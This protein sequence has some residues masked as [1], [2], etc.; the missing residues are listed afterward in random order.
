M[1][2]APSTKVGI[3]QVRKWPT[4]AD[5]GPP[6]EDPRMLTHDQLMAFCRKF[7][8]ER[9]LSVYLNADQRDPAQRTRWKTMLSQQL[10]AIRRGLP[11][12]ERNAFEEAVERVRAELDGFE[13]FLPKRGF[14]AFATSGGL[15][16]A[17]T[18]PVAMP[19]LARWEPGIRAAPYIRALGRR[20]P[21]VL[22]LVD[23]RRARLFC[24]Q[25]G[26]LKESG[27]FQADTF[28]GDLSDAHTGKRPTTRSGVRGQTSS[29]AAQRYL[30]VS[31]DHMVKAAMD[32]AV[33]RAG[34][35]GFL[36]VGGTPE[37]VSAAAALAPK[38]MDGRIRESPSLYVDIK[39]PELRPALEEIAMDMTNRY[40]SALLARLKDQARA[41]GRACLGREETERALSELRVDTLLIS[42]TLVEHE[43]DYADRVVGMAFLGGA[44]VEELEAGAGDELQRDGDGLAARLR[45]RNRTA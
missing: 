12:D 40:R 6:P 5:Y 7:Q 17:E 16:Y 26:T 29:D 44:D 39:D 34:H 31:W 23:A 25:D 18:L 42:R 38:G 9:V 37:R 19:D 11:G 8:D 20:R 43:P 27:G 30:E 22:L 21:L 4:R 24:Y 15:H 33:R 14:V 28:V 45:F 32:D 10:D 35:Q 2:C 36:V 41:G 13:T 3:E 1:Q